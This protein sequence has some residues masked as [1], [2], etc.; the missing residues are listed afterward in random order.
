MTLF[1]AP[2]GEYKHYRGL[3]T[4]LANFAISASRHGGQLLNQIF[5]YSKDITSSPGYLEGWRIFK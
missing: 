4:K 2:G 3:V 1:T 5:I